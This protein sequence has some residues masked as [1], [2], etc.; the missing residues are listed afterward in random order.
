LI[1]AAMRP[2]SVRSFWSVVAVV[3][4]GMMALA[5]FSRWIG[6][7]GGGSENAIVGVIW[8][9]AAVGLGFFMFHGV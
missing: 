5:P 1:I 9:A 8:V 3:A 2:E 4:I 6:G 7:A